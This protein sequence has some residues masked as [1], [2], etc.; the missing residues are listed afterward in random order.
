MPEIRHRLFKSILATSLAVT[1]MFFKPDRNKQFHAQG[2]LSKGPLGELIAVSRPDLAKDDSSKKGLLGL[3]TTGGAA[4]CREGNLISERN[5][6]FSRDWST[7]LPI[8]RFPASILFP[9]ATQLPHR[10]Q[11]RAIDDRDVRPRHI[12]AGYIQQGKQ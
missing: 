5:V 7:L 6:T 10:L 8:G 1:M 11:N 3:A 12:A 9:T 2:R 4:R